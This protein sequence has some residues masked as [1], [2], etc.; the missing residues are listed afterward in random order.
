MKLTSTVS[1]LLRIQRMN[2][3]A[4]Q[5]MQRRNIYLVPCSL[6]FHLRT[7]RNSTRTR[8]EH[9]RELE[10]DWNVPSPCISRSL[11]LMRRAAMLGAGT[12][13]GDSSRTGGA[14]SRASLVT[15]KSQT[16][17]KRRGN[18]GGI[19]LSLLCLCLNNR[20]WRFITKETTGFS[21]SA[22]G[23]IVLFSGWN[24]FCCAFVWR[25]SAPFLKR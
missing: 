1:N 23:I 11:P 16:K 8:L 4:D 9:C 2:G 20:Q 7:D 12:S 14:S 25:E 24:E 22:I 6:S 3:Y 21:I 19:M 17:K 15:R 10:H 13:G 18:S 5:E